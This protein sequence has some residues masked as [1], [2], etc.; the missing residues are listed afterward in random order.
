MAN[1]ASLEDRAAV[2]AADLVGPLQS[3]RAVGLDRSI[4]PYG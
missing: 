4:D 1:L 3:E 2:E